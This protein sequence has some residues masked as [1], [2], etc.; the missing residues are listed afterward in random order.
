MIMIIPYFF[1]LLI[2]DKLLIKKAKWY[3]LHM[4][5]NS[6]I[7]LLTINDVIHL[8]M[9]PL[10]LKDI[11]NT[12]PQDI[13]MALHIYHMV[14]FRNLL[15]IDWIHHIIMMIILIFPYNYGETLMICNYLLFFLS[16]LPGGI[17][18]MMLIMVKY[19]KMKK[20]TE[21]YINSKL[22]LWIRSPGI[23]IGA[24]IL[25]LE[26]INNLI[27]GHLFILIFSLI[28]LIWNA[29]YFTE[30]VMTN[31]VYKLNFEIKKIDS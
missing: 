31:Y 7:V 8:I 6:L 4:L 16:G 11:D 30:R 1:I 15:L 9:N 12:I 17:D 2:I 26:Y 19:E 5:T 14:M 13:T 3:I 20:M 23:I 22:N 29:Q 27:K 25:F 24:Y 21:K 18:Y 28:G 10:F